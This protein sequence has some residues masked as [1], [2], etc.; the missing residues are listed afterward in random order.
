MRHRIFLLWAAFLTVGLGCSGDGRSEVS[1]TVLLNGVPLEEGAIA[2]I[3]TDGNQ[4]P[5]AGAVITDGRYH[6][7]HSSGVTP[8]RNRV[9]LR[10][11]RYSGRKV[12]DPMGPPG[13]LTNER[14]PAFPP[15][16]NERS[17]LTREVRKGS[18]TIDFDIHV[19]EPAKPAGKR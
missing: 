5:E 14:V 15:E 3:P 11:F 13:S 4:G 10:A 7:P 18:D 12:P 19:D 8:G 1:G 17:T 2:F 16:F 9:E 6:I